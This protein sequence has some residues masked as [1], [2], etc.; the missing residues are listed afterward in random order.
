MVDMGA[1]V[2]RR[3]FSYSLRTLF[4]AMTTVGFL[5]AWS[6]YEL[7]WIRERHRLEES[8]RVHRTADPSNVTLAPGLL[9][10]FGEQGHRRVVFYIDLTGH[11][12]DD[13]AKVYNTDLHQEM[14][15]AKELF[16]EATIAVTRIFLLS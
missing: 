4:V 14:R 15:K 3:R 12:S 9:W 11:P 6:L 2:K 13:D 1:A 16:P 8:G 5:L 7:N 10:L